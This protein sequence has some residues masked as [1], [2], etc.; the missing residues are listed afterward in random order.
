MLG[1]GNL[2]AIPFN[3]E[4]K[5]NEDFLKIPESDI[6][7]VIEKESERPTGNKFGNIKSLTSNPQNGEVSDWMFAE[8]GIIA[9]SVYLGNKEGTSNKDFPL[10][11]ITT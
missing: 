3:Y 11:G 9:L 8:K 4:S 1:N 5:L 2:F 6:Y 7:N 10:Q